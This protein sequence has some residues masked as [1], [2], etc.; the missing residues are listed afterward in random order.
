MHSTSIQL[1]G[2][3]HFVITL[4]CLSTEQPQL[5]YLPNIGTSR[6]IL[7][8]FYLCFMRLGH[9]QT[10]CH[11]M[12][13]LK[14]YKFLLSVPSCKS[15]WCTT[16]SFISMQIIQTYQNIKFLTSFRASNLS[17]PKTVMHLEIGSGYTLNLRSLMEL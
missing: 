1:A 6:V 17:G 16:S 14:D 15:A 4:K 2:C 11:S 9:W 13:I 7:K 3:K 8:L 10:F 12:A 5:E